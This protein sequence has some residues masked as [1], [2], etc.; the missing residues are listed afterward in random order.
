MFA[1]TP[2]KEERRSVLGEATEAV[3]VEPVV[4]GDRLFVITLMFFCF[5]S[6]NLDHIQD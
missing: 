3:D 6:N 1:V 2:E 4:R 5:G